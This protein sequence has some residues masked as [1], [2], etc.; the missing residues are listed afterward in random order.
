MLALVLVSIGTFF[1]EL[2]IALGKAK[3]EHNE[4]TIYS[5]AF[6]SYIWATL[7]FFLIILYKGN[8]VFS[9]ASLPT[10]IPRLLIELILA[11]IT[12]LAIIRSDRSTFGFI[13]TGTIPLLLLTDLWMGY[14]L[15][16]TQLFGI[17]I[18]AGTLLV[19]FM[20]HGLQREGIMLVVW[21]TILP[22]ATIALYKYN[23]TH[24]NSVEAEQFLTHLALLIY[25]FVM[26]MKVGKE[27]PFALFI[28]RK[29][30]VQSFAAGLAGVLVSFAYLFAAASTIIA[31]KRAIAVLG[32]IVSGNRYFA[33]KGLGL[34][35]ILFVLVSVGI[36]L[37]V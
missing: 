13:R 25:L 20:N 1:D 19:A 18:L 34:K 2:S 23:I 32:A 22:I 28:K 17:L 24:F 27:N 3:V 36:I 12:T 6:L 11:H 33:E 10:F 30:F 37:L 5:M 26:A 35:I 15:S 8:F 16:T 7:W 9:L 31:A 4:Q 21:A 14:T 29:F